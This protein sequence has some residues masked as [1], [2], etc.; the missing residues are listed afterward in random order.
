MRRDRRM[1]GLVLMMPL[2]ELMIFGY[3]VATDIDHISLAVCD[4]SQTAQSRAYVEH[5]EQSRYFRVRAAC[6][7]V[8]DIDH[9]LDRGTVRVALVIPPDFAARLARGGPAQVMAAVDGTNSNTAMIAISYLEQATLGQA[10][11]VIDP[12]GECEKTFERIG[13]VGFDILRR[14]AGVKRRHDD[15]GE[16]D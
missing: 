13:N 12:G 10:I 1:F 9:L 16:I 4:Y 14:H 6:G 11:D 2:L 5:L 8:G 15:F 3:V 7:R